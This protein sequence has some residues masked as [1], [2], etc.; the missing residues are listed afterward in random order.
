MV[1]YCDAPTSTVKS[2]G[3]DAEKRLEGYT[4]LLLRHFALAVHVINIVFV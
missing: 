1:F 3:E 2:D 4:A